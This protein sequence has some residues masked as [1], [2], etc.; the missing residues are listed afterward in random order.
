MQNLLPS[1]C[2]LST[3]G[4]ESISTT[5]AK[6]PTLEQDRCAVVGLQV[7]D[8]KATF[9]S[10][11]AFA[12]AVV[13]MRACGRGGGRNMQPLDRRHYRGGAPQGH[14]RRP[15]Q[16]NLAV[17]QLDMGVESDDGVKLPLTSQASL[18]D[19]V[20]I[21]TRAEEL[22]F[23]SPPESLERATESRDLVVWSRPSLRSSVQNSLGRGSLLE[24]SCMHKLTGQT[25]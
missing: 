14:L 3:L 6:G 7:S 1:S 11:S 15:A 21:E 5:S 17:D 12:D 9:D 20:G 10:V 22:S 8:G 24:A 19:H 18:P 4:K 23:H 16:R 13:G 25:T 2:K